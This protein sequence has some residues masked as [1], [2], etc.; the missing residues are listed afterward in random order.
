MIHKIFLILLLLVCC[1][2]T[3]KG[4]TIYVPDDHPTIQDAVNASSNW[5]TI[6][7]R[8]GTYVENVHFLGKIIKLVSEMGP[9]RTVIDGSRPINPYCGSVIIFERGETRDS[10]VE[11]FCI[12]NGSG[13]FRC[14]TL[15][16]GG[17]IYCYNDSSPTIRGNIIRGNRAD[18]GGGIY[19]GWDCSPLIT[20]NTIVWNEATVLGGGGIYCGG[21][22]SIIRNN[23]IEN[24][25][26][27]DGD[28]GGLT[29]YGLDVKVS[30]NII[31]NNSALR[32]GGV[33]CS[34]KTDSIVENNL[35]SNNTAVYG[36]GLYCRSN[37]SSNVTSNI[38]NGNEAT[39]SGGGL[40]CEGEAAMIFSNNMIFG[41]FAE[42]EGGGMN[43]YG[44][45][46]F[47]NNTIVGNRAIDYGG[48]I[49]C[50]N[51]PTEMVNTVLWGNDADEGPEISIGCWNSYNGKL[52]IH[53]SDV[54]GGESAAHVE[55]GGVLEYGHGNIEAYPMFVEPVSCDLH[56][57]ANSPCR[58]AGFGQLA[59]LPPSDFEGDPRIS[60]GY[61]DMGADEFYPHL[62]CRGDV[63]P[64]GMIELRVIGPSGIFASLAL[65]AAVR[66]PPWTTQ[67]GDLHLRLP[68]RNFPLGVIPSDGVVRFPAAVPGFW[69]PGD[70]KPMQALVGR[71]VNPAAML[72]NLLIL[73]VE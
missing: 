71:L 7:V 57:T 11:G 25:S 33:Y 6:V 59:D 28:G 50:E 39:L 38:I 70:I 36:G 23:L 46:L 69:Q 48:G 27:P 17:G 35:I 55:P 22:S 16:Q 52:T 37:S 65:G 24:N 4:T 43:I 61:V 34:G 31:R 72:T 10:V 18:S 5:D 54:Q 32:G 15:S 53:F 3:A 66:D 13:Y 63:T 41:N 1:D 12:A 62:Y 8:P 30:N 19:S 2:Q 58:D 44:G 51:G 29:F 67:Y 21:D 9:E 42:S 40:C 68:I 45:P 60:G 26:V 14:S 47:I 64:G 49:R 56:L 73:E 20:D